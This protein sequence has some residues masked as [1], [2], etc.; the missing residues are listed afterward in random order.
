MPRDHPLKHMELGS[1]KSPAEFIANLVRVFDLVRD[2]MADHACAFINIG[3]TYNGGVGERGNVHGTSLKHA[4]EFDKLDRKKQKGIDSGNLCLIPQRLAISLQDA[5]WIVR[6][7]IIW[8]LSPSTVLYART[9][10]TEGPMTIHDLVRLDPSTVK[11]WTGQKWSQVRGW[12]ETETAGDTIKI[13]LRS[14]ESFS[15]TANHQWP[16]ADGRVVRADELRYGTDLF[17]GDILASTQIPEP[18]NPEGEE[19]EDLAWFAGLYLA[20]GSISGNCISIS[21][22]TKEAWRHERVQAI[23]KKYGGSATVNNDHG[24]TITVRVHGNIMIGAISHFLTGKKAHGKHINP[25]VWRSSN[26]ILQSLLNGYLHGDGS[27]DDKNSRWRLGFCR[28]Y[29]LAQDIRT[30]CGR[31]G[32]TLTLNPTFAKIGKTKVFESFRGEIRAT[33]S[34]HHN[35]KSRQE[36]VRIDKG[37]GGTFYDIGIEDE[38]HLFALA[39]GVLTHNSKPSAMPQSLSGW[40]W[41]RCRVKTSG[42][43]EKNDPRGGFRQGTSERNGHDGS[44]HRVATWSDCPGCKNCRDSNGYVLRRGSWRPTSSYEPI[45]ML[46]KSKNYFADGEPVKTPAAAATISR[47]LYSRVLD[48]PDEQFAVAHDHE[49]VCDSGANLR[50]VWRIAAEPLKESHYASFPTELVRRCLQCST[51]ARG[52]CPTCGKPLVRMID[53]KPSDSRQEGNEWQNGRETANHH[54]PSRPGSFTDGETKTIGWRQSCSCAPVE[55]R[56]AKVL[57]PF[58]GS[59]RTGI[60]AIRLG[61]DF[62]GVELN[63]SYVAMSRRI[64]KEESPLFS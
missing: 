57:D 58:A 25:R 1:E 3:D 28:N 54:G 21:G 36:V 37:W 38:P 10:R 34:E 13:T 29:D 49:T 43:S 30:I 56:P 9:A 39:S 15:C 12:S 33:Q 35:A 17:D 51:S 27:W 8:C 4:G 16:L 62:V 64:L 18:E 26:R 61:L 44:A 20:E 23:A 50:D 6:S 31:L 59:G 52:Y 19:L 46:A 22:H 41:R 55:P 48:D 40:S 42:R 2:C 32:L 63:E 5:G 14:G 11:L 53:L 24:D 7:V 47:D 60:A 45:L